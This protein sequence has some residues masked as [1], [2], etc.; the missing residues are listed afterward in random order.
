MPLLYLLIFH[1]AQLW[2][3]IDLA[4][5]DSKFSATGLLDF[6]MMRLTEETKES[7]RTYDLRKVLGKYDG[8]V[9]KFSISIESDDSEFLADEQE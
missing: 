5:Y 1:S 3:V 8:N 7:I 9:V 6:D 4:K 2:E